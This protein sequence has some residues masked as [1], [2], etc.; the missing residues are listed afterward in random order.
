MRALR[1]VAR[2]LGLAA[3]TAG[4][5]V[6]ALAGRGVLPRAPLR[7]RGRRALV[8][9]W[10]RGALVLLNVR[11]RV[12][13]PHPRPPFLLVCNHLSYVDVLV[14]A[15]E[16]GARFVAK[17]EVARWPVL[18]L[19]A[20]A[21]GTLFVDRDRPRDLRRAG[22][23]VGEALASGAGLVLFPEGTSTPGDAV[24]PFRPA[25]LEPAIA[26]G[27]P[28]HWAALAY[29]TPPGEPPAREAVAWW[30]DARFAPH[31]LGL[32][33]LA[34]VDARLVLGGHPLAGRHRGELARALHASVADGL[35]RGGRAPAGPC[36]AA[37]DL[38]LAL[39]QG[40]ELVGGLTPEIYGAAPYPLASSG[41]GP[42]VRHVLDCVQR[43][44]DGLATG[45]VDYDR[46]ERERLLE[47]DPRH[48]ARRLWA[49]AR[50]VRAL[51]GSDPTRPLEVRME[52]APEVPDARACARSSLARELSYVLSHTVHHY[53]LAAVL[54]RHQ[55]VEP[56]PE[57]GVAP[58]TLRHWKESGRCA[59][60]AG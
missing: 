1:I 19:L 59:P 32:L 37:E 48:A 24:L 3:W 6:L 25:L 58:A 23:A 16:T 4:L 35:G 7:E 57:L 40:A 39:E 11:A 15:A 29:G 42:H 56:G 49:L 31:L 22:A 47:V 14:L 60:P 21:G 17:A 41:V 10:A 18:G 33:G 9:R 13:G 52:V 45:R 44:L 38:A 53:A 51:A 30:G 36:A 54:L 28:V 26:L 8:R 34:R 5:L 50:H 43:L 27:L 12:S 55:G 2:G 46:R 20:R